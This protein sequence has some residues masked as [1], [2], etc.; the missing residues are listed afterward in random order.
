MFDVLAETIVVVVFVFVEVDVGV[1][2]D[3]AE[4]NPERAETGVDLPNAYA[5]F[6]WV[7]VAGVAARGTTPRSLGTRTPG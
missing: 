2:A 3:D 7:C 4:E 5:G 6:G 1:G